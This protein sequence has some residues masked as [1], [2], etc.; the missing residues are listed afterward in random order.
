[1]PATPLH[2]QCDLGEG[3]GV[4]CLHQIAVFVG[5]QNLK[6]FLSCYLEPNVPICGNA[7][8]TMVVAVVQWHGHAITV[9]NYYY[10]YLTTANDSWDISVASAVAVVDAT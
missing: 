1:M 2:L 3:C 10:D 8:G 5:C 7:S 9:H 6:L 4:D